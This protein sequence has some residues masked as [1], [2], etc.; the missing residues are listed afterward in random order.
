M[1]FIRLVPKQMHSTTAGRYSEI[2]Q[3]TVIAVCA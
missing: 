1:S 2:A 3:N